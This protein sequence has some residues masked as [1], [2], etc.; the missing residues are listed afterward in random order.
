MSAMMGES[1]MLEHEQYIRHD[2]KP[3]N[4]HQPS[5]KATMCSH[6]GIEESAHDKDAHTDL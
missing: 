4:I 2:S 1:T 3:I 6:T 5:N